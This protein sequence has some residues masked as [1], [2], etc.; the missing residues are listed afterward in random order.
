[1]TRHHVSRVRDGFA[2]GHI[3]LDRNDRLA[4]LCLKRIAGHEI[5]DPGKHRHAAL[6][7]PNGAGGTDSRRG[8]CDQNESGGDH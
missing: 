4:S 5:P 3:Q 2:V 1:M 8:T 6:C 7:T